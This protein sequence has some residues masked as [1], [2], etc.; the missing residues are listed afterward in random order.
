MSIASQAKHSAILYLA[1]SVGIRWGYNVLYLL[2]KGFTPMQH[3]ILHMICC[4]VSL[5]LAFMAV[6]LFRKSSP[7]GSNLGC[8]FVVLLLL[9]FAFAVGSI[10]AALIHLFGANGGELESI[11]LM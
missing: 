11:W 5:A 9:N 1:M 3:A 2:Y 8:V 10:F 4:V 6:Q 7:S